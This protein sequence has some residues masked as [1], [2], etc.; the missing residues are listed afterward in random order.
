MLAWI[1]SSPSVLYMLVG[2]IF[3]VIETDANPTEIPYKGKPT[4][5]LV[6]RHILVSFA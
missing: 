3:L 4:M 5:S 1:N 6:Y 2:A